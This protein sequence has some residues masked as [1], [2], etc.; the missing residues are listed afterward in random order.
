MDQRFCKQILPPF[1][2]RWRALR[3]CSVIA[4]NIPANYIDR[5][6]IV[7]MKAS[8]FLPLEAIIR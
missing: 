7:L 5:V 6:V 8:R 4:G 2:V 1:S 3:L